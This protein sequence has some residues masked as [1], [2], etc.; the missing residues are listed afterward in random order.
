MNPQDLDM[1]QNARKQLAHHTE[2]LEMHRAEAG[3][4]QTIIDALEG[5]PPS[6]EGPSVAE[7]VYRAAKDFTAK[8][9]ETGKTVVFDYDNLRDTAKSTLTP[10]QLVSFNKGIYA[11]ITSLK[12]QNKIKVAPG[13]HSLN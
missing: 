13:G 11:A 9:A 7:L 6:V 4:Y 1:L 5:R 2:Q 10:E 8:H 12:R 3:K